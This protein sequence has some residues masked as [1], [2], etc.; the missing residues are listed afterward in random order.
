MPATVLARLVLL[1]L[2]A[3]YPVWVSHVARNTTIRCALSPINQ[4]GPGSR[5][6]V[7]FTTVIVTSSWRV[8]RFSSV[9]STVTW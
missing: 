8:L 2:G 1:G 6:S 7:R 3:T 5:Q 9:A 4:P